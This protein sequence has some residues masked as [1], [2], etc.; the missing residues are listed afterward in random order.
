MKNNMRSKAKKLM[1]KLKIKVVSITKI[2]FS[3]FYSLFH[4]VLIKKNLAFSSFSLSHAVLLFLIFGLQIQ[5]VKASSFSSSSS[6]STTN[7]SFYLPLDKANALINHI[8][9]DLSD[10][11]SQSEEI[12][13]AENLAAV[14]PDVSLNAS[15]NA[16]D[17]S[18]NDEEEARK[19]HQHVQSHIKRQKKEAKKQ[20]HQIKKE[21]LETKAFAQYQ[22]EA[23][24]SQDRYFNHLIGQIN[25]EQ[26][27]NDQ[28]NNTV[29]NQTKDQHKEQKNNKSK[30]EEEKNEDESCISCFIGA[31]T[32]AKKEVK[33]GE[34]KEAKKESKK[35]REGYSL[36]STVSSSFSSPL[37]SSASSTSHSP[38]FYAFISFSLPDTSLKELAYQ[39]KRMG[40]T[41]GVMVLRGL[42]QD[43]FKQTA[44]HIQSLNKEGVKAII[45]PK[46][47]NFFNVTQVPTYVF[48]CKKRDREREGKK[49]VYDKLIGNVTAQYALERFKE[50]GECYEEA[51]E[52]LRLLSTSNKIWDKKQC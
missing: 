38:L 17:V 20:H 15:N 25:T 33:T 43:S 28:M 24:Q 46:L 40:K 51:A 2:L 21:V 16:L 18:L 47:F 5:G 35:E 10:L 8:Q 45:H 6:S 4:D 1:R 29:K 23:Q 39:L 34:R 36:L 22:T 27:R 37:S 19:I 42:D 49:R 14:L 50:E 13:E 30:E 44:K 12:K 52:I 41:N 9:S 26:K 3:L 11:S 32:G 31:K 48:S 7:S